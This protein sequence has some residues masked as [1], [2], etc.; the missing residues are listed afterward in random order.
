MHCSPG[1]HL[2]MCRCARRA[3]GAAVCRQARG[4]GRT[5]KKSV[6]ELPSYCWGLVMPAHIWPRS[7]SQVSTRRGSGVRVRSRKT[8]SSTVRRLFGAGVNSFRLTCARAQAGR[9]RSEL[10]RLTAPGQWSHSAEAG[11]ALVC[12]SIPSARGYRARQQAACLEDGL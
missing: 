8:N 5:S 1:I 12:P 11:L 2:V 4:A 10:A 3:S 6:K 7:A 9:W